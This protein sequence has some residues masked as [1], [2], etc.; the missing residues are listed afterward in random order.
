MNCK[1]LSRCQSCG[2]KTRQCGLPS[3]DVQHDLGM[4][5]CSQCKLVSYCSVEH[6]KADWKVHKQYCKSLVR[7]PCGHVVVDIFVLLIEKQFE[8]F[9]QEIMKYPE[10]IHEISTT[11]ASLVTYAVHTRNLEIIQFIVERGASVTHCGTNQY[12]ITA[13]QGVLTASAAPF[14]LNIF[15]Y[16]LDHGAHPDQP[17]AEGKILSS[18]LTSYGELVLIIIIC[19]IHD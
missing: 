2:K 7:W 3:C 13:L 11:D 18:E 1:P 4:K 10:R 6:Q 5:K 16:L 19:M 15:E 12:N 14:D 9:K 17:N 8:A